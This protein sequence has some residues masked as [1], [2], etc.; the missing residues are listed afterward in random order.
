[1]PRTRIPRTQ[2]YGGSDL[3]AHMMKL[4]KICYAMVEYMWVEYTMHT[5]VP[6]RRQ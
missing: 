4:H 2:I 5:D 3:R 6:D 1:M